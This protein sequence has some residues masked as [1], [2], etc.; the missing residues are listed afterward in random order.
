[1]CNSCGADGILFFQWR[2]SVAGAEKFHSGM[3]PHAGT[4][5]RVW[6]EIEQLGKELHSLGQITGSRVSAS[7]A[8][9]FDWDSWW[10]IEQQAVPAEVPY[11]EGVSA[12]HRELYERNIAVDF[13]RPT[14]DMSAYGLVIVP[15]MFVATDQATGNLNTYVKDGGQLLVT[16]LT[17]VTDENAHIS[18]GG[19]L[20]GLRETLGIWIEEFA[21]LATGERVGLG[22]IPATVDVTKAPISAAEGEL[23]TEYVHLSGAT[24]KAMFTSGALTDW[25]ALTRNETGSG[26]AWYLATMPEEKARGDLIEHLLDEAGIALASIR[27]RPGVEVVMRGDYTFIINHSAA[28]TSVGLSGTD[29]LTGRPADTVVLGMHE[30]AIVAARH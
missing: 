19:Y 21:P 14:D 8:I 20:G 2:Q 28:E 23:W 10:S 4:E 11:I 22:P 16:Y 6:R 29:L 12:W 25:P 13:V 7:V 15:N 30:V 18:R 1:M 27:P 9:V 5:T 3:L 17:A 26:A 24:T